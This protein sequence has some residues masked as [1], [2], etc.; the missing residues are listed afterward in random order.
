MRIRINLPVLLAIAGTAA[1]PAAARTH[2]DSQAWLT[3]SGSARLS[4]RFSLGLS[5][6]TRFGDRAGGLY[7]GEFGGTLS[8]DLGD[9]LSFTAGYARVIGYDNGHATSIENRPSEA[10]GFTIARLGGA[11]LT[12]RV[13]LEERFRNTGSDMGLRLVPKLQLTVPFRP[14]SAT[15]LVVSHESYVQLNHTDW[16]QQRGYSRM[17]NLIGVKTALTPHLTGEVDYLNQLD[18][19]LGGAD[20]RMANVALLGVSLRF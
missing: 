13:K 1:S 5:T 16:G 17:R 18:F 19:G 2:A 7:E 3:A 20:N 11:S 8:A 15:A 9:G 12:G 10:I 14:G 4:D 6:I